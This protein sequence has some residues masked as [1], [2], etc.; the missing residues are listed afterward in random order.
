M[1]QHTTST[2]AAAAAYRKSRGGGAGGAG[3]SSS[4]VSSDILQ[5]SAI[6][7]AMT[8]ST[9]GDS[10]LALMATEEA[11]RVAQQSKDTACVAFALGWL[12]E[13]H[14]QDDVQRRQLL[15]R[16]AT[17]ASA[18]G[19]SAATMTANKPGQPHL[20]HM[21]QQQQMSQAAQA[22]AARAQQLRPLVSGAHLALAR[23]DL[24][25]EVAA[26]AAGDNE[27]TARS[28]HT[29]VTGEHNTVGGQ[30]T[31]SSSVYARAWSN[32]LEVTSEPSA[33]PGTVDRPT[34][35]TPHP[36][37]TRSTLATTSL[38][39]DLGC[40]WNAGFIN[41]CDEIDLVVTSQRPFVR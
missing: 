7:L 5:F 20:H 9:F 17:R 28:S 29:T 38:C 2:T 10:D 27:A 34:H 12:Y 40:S 1:V 4:P 35:L 30:S 19:I 21:H 11:V 23:H 15:E 37:D 25:D 33:D 31:R 26:A 13:H 6:L 14:G 22:N 32:L 24:L 39:C 18:A 36:S 16:C 8:H 3:S 41:M